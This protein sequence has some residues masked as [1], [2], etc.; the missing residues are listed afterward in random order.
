MKH[1]MY[2]AYPVREYGRDACYGFSTVLYFVSVI[3]AY[4]QKIDLCPLFYS[5]KLVNLLTN[6]VVRLYFL[7]IWSSYFWIVLGN[8]A[9]ENLKLGI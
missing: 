9:D 3:T 8:Q 7:F 2:C 1:V 5:I 4:T 6:L